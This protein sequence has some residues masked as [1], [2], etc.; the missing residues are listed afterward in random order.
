[1][2][3]NSIKIGTSKTTRMI[4]TAGQSGRKLAGR[5]GWKRKRGRKRRGVEEE[6][7]RG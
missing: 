6:K 5:E 4:P 2:Q 1:M 3:E 7:G